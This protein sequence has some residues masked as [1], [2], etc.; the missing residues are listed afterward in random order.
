MITEACAVYCRTEVVPYDSI[1]CFLVPCRFLWRPISDHISDQS[2]H[3]AGHRLLVLLGRSP[4]GL[5]VDPIPHRR[6]RVQAPTKVR[7]RGPQAETHGRSSARERLSP[8]LKWQEEQ[9]LVGSLRPLLRPGT[10]SQQGCERCGSSP[11]SC[12]PGTEGPLSQEV[13]RRT[14]REVLTSSKVL[15]NG[16]QHAR[17]SLLSHSSRWLSRTD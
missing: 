1:D 6:S 8:L 12:A 14:E 17:R 15:T 7:T 5:P 11:R 4:I 2:R 3:A 9:L 10:L 13:L 16:P